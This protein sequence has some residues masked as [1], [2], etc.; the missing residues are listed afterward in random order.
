MFR[1]RFQG[2][3]L[4]KLVHQLSGVGVQ[5]ACGADSAPPGIQDPYAY[6]DVP[7]RRRDRDWK[8]RGL[9][10]LCFRAVT[11]AKPLMALSGPLSRAWLTT[12]PP[13][14]YDGNFSI[15]FIRERHS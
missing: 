13:T 4:E 1:L 5:N 11:E 10:P 12:L 8:A 6:L 3:L 15:C 9:S 7:H 2:P 14:L